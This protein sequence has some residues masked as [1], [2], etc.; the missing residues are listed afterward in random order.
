[1]ID[2]ETTWTDEVMSI[3]A[4]IADGRDFSVIDSRYYLIDPAFRR[5]GMYSGALRMCGIP[6]EIISARHEMAADMRKWLETN[7]VDSIFAYN[8]FLV[9]HACYNHKYE[10]RSAERRQL[11]P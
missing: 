7:S 6:K 10:R 9:R 3:G 11:F 5:G 1:M 2:T 8:A 4:V